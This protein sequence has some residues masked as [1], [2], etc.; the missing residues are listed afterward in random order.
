MQK[1]EIKKVTEQVH[2]LQKLH[3][4]S[5]DAIAINRQ[6]VSE[7]GYYLEKIKTFEDLQIKESVTIDINQEVIS[8]FWDKIQDLRA[9]N[10]EINTYYNSLKTLI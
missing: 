1:T 7:I 2:E 6:I 8:L 3:A 4:A 10:N 5:K 9:I